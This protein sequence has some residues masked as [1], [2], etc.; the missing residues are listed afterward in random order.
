MRAKQRGKM[1]P[2]VLEIAIGMKV[3]VTFNIDTN[4]DI[5]NGA[6]GIIH[7][8]ILSSGDDENVREDGSIRLGHLPVCVLVKLDRTRAAGME[9]MPEGVIPV[10]PLEKEFTIATTGDGRVLTVKRFQLPLTAAYAFTD[11]RAQ[12]QTIPYVLI[13]I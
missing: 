10:V 11:Y 1:L 7:D 6:R 2:D 12:G 4:S 8:I 3:M 5:T 13:D 9:G